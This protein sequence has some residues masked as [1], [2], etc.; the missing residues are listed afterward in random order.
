MF[1]TFHHT[2]GVT[3]KFLFLPGIEVRSSI[4]ASPV[5]CVADITLTTLTIFQKRQRYKGGGG[6]AEL[7][8]W[9]DMG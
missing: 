8:M 9:R 4:H 3:I 6:P 2:N 5:G 1:V 7:I